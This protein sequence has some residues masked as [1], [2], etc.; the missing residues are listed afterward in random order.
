MLSCLIQYISNSELFVDYPQ[1]MYALSNCIAIL[2]MNII[3]VY[4]LIQCCGHLHCL[5][6]NC[7][8]CW[9][10]LAK[11]RSIHMFSLAA[12]QTNLFQCILHLSQECSL[13]FTQA[14]LSLEYS[15]NSTF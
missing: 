9:N 13:C 8:Q 15:S 5:K 1:S 12:L 14:S 6:M 4:E 7:S 2:S 10:V 3:L 11:I